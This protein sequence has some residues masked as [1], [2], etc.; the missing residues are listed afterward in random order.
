MNEPAAAFASPAAAA[1]Q[2]AA[3]DVPPPLWLLAE[4]TY[5]CPLHCVFCS[6][7]VNYAAHNRE[8]DTAQWLDVL[9]E[10]RALGA[11]QLGF[12]GGEPLLRDDLEVLV[13]EARKLG[14]YTN[15]ITSGI[16]LTDKRIGDLKAAGLD[17]IQLSFQDS[18]QE[19][20]DFLS[21][22]RT[23][24]LKRRVASLIKAHGFPMVLNCVLH[25]YNLPHVDRIIEMALAM[26][27]E[28]LEL[29]NTQYY[30]WAKANQAQ[31]M[32]TREQLEEAEA[33]VQRYRETHGDLCKIFFVVPDYFERRPKRCMNGW[34]AVFLGVAPDGTALP[35]HAARDLPGLVFPKVT[36]QPLRSIWYE[37]DAFNHY[38]GT[39]WMK[40]PCR[41]CDE[42]EKDLGGC[43][44]QAYLL[45]GDAANA[46]PVCDKSPLHEKV[47]S[48]VREAAVARSTPISALREQPILF[49]NDANS[50]AL[51]AQTEHTDHTSDTAGAV[52]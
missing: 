46:D 47:V 16:G 11:A 44:C 48:V 5:R 10:A 7:P 13:A 19:L 31:L 2:T 38:R 8:L 40:E 3:P 1:S 42:K 39:S 50:R 23:F 15:L 22:T 12:S 36:E 41:S 52:R 28:Y 6:N 20:N 37:S 51:A 14:F 33:V 32:P 34:G 17:H 29:A 4:L 26:G 21:S 27:A 43:R 24:D 49:R 45:T 35:C 30:G 9:R 25:R 18:T